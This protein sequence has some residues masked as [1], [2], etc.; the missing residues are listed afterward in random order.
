M[1]T[2]TPKMRV[3]QEAARVNLA[4]GRSMTVGNFAAMMI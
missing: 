4:T 1:T 3:A 2:K